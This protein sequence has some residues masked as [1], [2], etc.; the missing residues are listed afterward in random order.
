MLFV[1]DYLEVSVGSTV[2]FDLVDG[3]DPDHPLGFDP[4]LQYSTMSSGNDTLLIFK[5]TQA[6]NFKFFCTIH[7]ISGTIVVK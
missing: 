7:G 1:P 2:I 4:P 5:F 6:M 3:P